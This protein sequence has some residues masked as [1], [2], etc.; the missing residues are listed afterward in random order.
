M[1]ENNQNN[2]NPY[3]EQNY[4]SKKPRK[5]GKGFGIAS[6]VLGIFVWCFFVIISVI[7]YTGDGFVSEFE[8]AIEIVVGVP[9][10][11]LAVIFGIIQKEVY[12]KTKMA[13]AGIVIGGF[14]PIFILLIFAFMLFIII[15]ALFEELSPAFSSW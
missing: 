7:G 10:A 6:M 3:M 4:K 11:I 14:F 9:L 8:L 5:P 12:E 2:Q 15:Y 1:H 13:T